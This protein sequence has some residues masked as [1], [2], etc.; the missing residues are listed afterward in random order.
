M[1]VSRGLTL[2][3][4]YGAA[5]HWLAVLTT[6]RPDGEPSIS[7]VNAAPI[8]HPVTDEAV[9]AFVARGG[10]A[11]IENLRQR[12]RAALTFRHGWDWI[13]V[14]GA[15]ELV[16]PDH[17]L[18]GVPLEAMRQLLRDIYA[19]AG[20]QHT[21]LAEYDRVMAAERRTAALLRPT[22]F[23]TNPAGTEHQ[24]HR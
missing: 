22:R 8:V 20:G 13:A 16:G 9:L 4:Q 24:E 6:I 12:P 5:E 1:N 11:K 15:T 3:S 17:P 23:A 18:T 14:H 10:T 19:A 2:A 21:D 7:V